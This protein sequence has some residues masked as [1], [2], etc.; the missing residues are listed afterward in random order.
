MNFD[1]NIDENCYIIEL[2]TNAHKFRIYFEHLLFSVTVSRLNLKTKKI[3][4]FQIQKQIGGEFL[5]EKTICFSESIGDF[6]LFEEN[7]LVRKEYFSNG[8]LKYKN[9]KFKNGT[10]LR[11]IYDSSGFLTSQINFEKNDLNSICKFWESNSQKYITLE[12]KNGKLI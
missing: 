11:K 10:G 8:N 7:E 3:I 9:I 6:D 2:T 4:S 5:F 1:F 12:Y